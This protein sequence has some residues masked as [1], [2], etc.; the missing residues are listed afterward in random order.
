M[1]ALS[2]ATDLG[3]GQPMEYALS[4][5]ILAI[6]LGESLHLDEAELS[7]VYYQALLRYIGCNAETHVL[8]ALFGD[9]LALRAE[10]AKVDTG[11]QSQFLS[12]LIRA[13]RQAN[14]GASPLRLVS[15]IAQGIWNS[16]SVVNDIVEG[17]CEVAQRFAERLG[18]NESVIYALGQLY[19][20]WDGK[21]SP[22]GVKGEEVAPAVL[23]V[24][25]AQD[26]ITFYRLGGVDAAAAIVR[27][28]KGKAYEPRMAEYF[29]SHAADLLAGLDQEPT[30][31]T[32][33]SMEPGA[34]QLLSEQQLDA[35]CEIIADFADIKSPYTGG[36]SRAVAELVAEA[37][38]CCGL[39]LADITAVHR[40][41]FIHDVG[42][43][44][45]STA[46]W[47]KPGPLSEREWE[48]VRLHPY[49]T[50]RIFARPASLARLGELAALHHE[51]LNGSGYHRGATAS[52]LSPAARILAA[53]NVYQALTETRPYRSAK[54]PD[55][56][57]DTLKRE[58]RAGRLDSEAVNGV[59]LAAGHRIGRP[60]Q[61]T[62]V[63]GLSEREMDVLCLIARGNSIKQI[64]QQLHIAE[65]TV[66]N[67]IQHIYN[68]IGVSTRAGATLFAIEQNLLSDTK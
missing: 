62:F 4:S 43:V 28:R 51:R 54:T 66:D 60:S 41:G 61:R 6:R 32:V 15:L 30:W 50:E 26:V 36:H 46:L 67:H 21:G 29:C 47:M 13:I 68:K 27:E 8:A 44:G 45:I 9:E 42:K 65:K 16:P 7:N 53:A 12:L 40:A 2:I 25:L 52:A 3:M 19:E 38:R 5:C 56:A 23:I 1:A 63:A 48:Q 11:S 57:A 39:P 37:A 34:R 17:H 10:L 49:Y 58:V 33:L 20:R 18:F 35:A 55:E 31:E 24:S 59:L 64:A 14:E 22:N